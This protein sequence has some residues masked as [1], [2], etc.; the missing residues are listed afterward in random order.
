LL[1]EVSEKLRYQ[2]FKSLRSKLDNLRETI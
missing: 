1:S 2:F